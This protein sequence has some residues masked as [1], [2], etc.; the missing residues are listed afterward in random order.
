MV[1]CGV[2]V[3]V[4]AESL[5]IISNGFGF[6]KLTDY[7]VKFHSYNLLKKRFIIN[8][9]NYRL[10]QLKNDIKTKNVVQIDTTL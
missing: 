3:E 4:R 5:N 9:N 7:V 2:L 1:K 6:R 10:K 8:R